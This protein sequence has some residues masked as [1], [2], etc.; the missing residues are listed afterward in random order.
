[1]PKTY[2]HLWQE[3]ISPDNIYSAYIEAIKGKKDTPEVIRFEANREENLI[4]LQNELIWKT[5]MP[6][7]WRIFTVYEPKQREIHA[8]AFR[9]RV[10]HHAVT[11]VIAPLFERKMYEHSYA[12][13]KNKGTH[14]AVKKAQIYTKEVRLHGDFFFLKCDIRHYFYSINHEI[15]KNIL[16][17][18]INDGDLL[19]YLDRL[20]DESGFG[21]VGLPI[22][23]LTSQ[24]FANVYLTELDHFVKDK[25]GI[26]KYIRYMDDFIIFD[27]DKQKLRELLPQIRDFLK[28]HLALDFNPKTRIHKGLEGVDFCG[29]RIWP[30]YILPRKRN[31]RRMRKRLRRMARLYTS[32]AVKMPA[33][34]QV[35]ASHLGYLKHCRDSRGLSI[36]LEELVL[37]R[38]G[39]MNGERKHADRRNKDPRN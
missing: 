24:L 15:L 26:K 1:M 2:G 22:G 27:S 3:I 21:E 17:R 13:R 9:D 19:W 16:D 39:F 38:E 25:L 18:T 33:I 6:S 32:G 5:W 14:E 20:L 8:P 36:F 10:I 31:V 7:P 35:L 37:T 12:C 11:R 23:A 28:M 34:E 4:T 29:Y 30:D